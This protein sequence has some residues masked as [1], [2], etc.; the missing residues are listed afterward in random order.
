MRTS[1]GKESLAETDR[2][3]PVSRA[4]SYAKELFPE[5][6]LDFCYWTVVCMEEYTGHEARRGKL[7]SDSQ[8]LGVKEPTS[9]W[10]QQ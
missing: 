7:G 6:P 3:V 5:G 1:P 2:V 9:F 4:L 8:G 10:R